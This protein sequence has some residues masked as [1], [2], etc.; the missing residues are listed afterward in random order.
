MADKDKAEEAER[1]YAVRCYV[2]YSC[3]NPRTGKDEADPVLFFEIDI[4]FFLNI[5]KCFRYRDKDRMP[6]SQ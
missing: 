2:H 3:T 6:H 1:V 4:D 5:N